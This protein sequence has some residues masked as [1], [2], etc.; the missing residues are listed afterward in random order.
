MTEDVPRAYEAAAWDALLSADYD[1]AIRQAWKWYRDEPF[2][3]MT[4]A[5][6]HS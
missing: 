3:P 2:A 5:F 6:S 4:H 1:E